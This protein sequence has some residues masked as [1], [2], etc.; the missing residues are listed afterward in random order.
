MNLS[1]KWADAELP[2]VHSDIDLGILSKSCTAQLC[3]TKT[4]LELIYKKNK[5]LWSW[6]K[7]LTFA[8]MKKA[9]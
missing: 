2:Y 9:Y 7:D 8:L 4:N 1:P 3:F 5:G 6:K